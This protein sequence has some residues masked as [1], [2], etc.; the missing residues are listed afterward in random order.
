ML[1]GL[2]ALFGLAVSE[3]PAMAR[4]SPHSLLSALASWLI[5]HLPQVVVHRGIVAFGEHDKR[6]LIIS[7]AAVAALVS[8]LTVGD[9]QLEA[10]TALMSAVV[11]VA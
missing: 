7:M 6:V 8:G 5:D 10:A 2:A 4:L 1:A 11:G 3:V 9:S